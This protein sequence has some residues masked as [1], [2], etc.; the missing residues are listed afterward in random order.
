MTTGG[1]SPPRRGHQPGPSLQVPDLQGVGL[2]NYPHSFG[3][4]GCL[5]INITDRPENLAIPLGT[6]DGHC[7]KLFGY[8]FDRPH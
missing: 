7:D 2:A 1:I 5:A 6:D 3:S 4:I 8:F